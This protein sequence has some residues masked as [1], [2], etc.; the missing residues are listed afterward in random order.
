MQHCFRIQSSPCRNPAYFRKMEKLID[1]KNLDDIIHDMLTVKVSDE[2]YHRA[3]KYR[4]TKI[5]NGLRMSDRKEALS[6]AGQEGT[7][8]CV[9][10][11]GFFPV[12]ADSGR[13]TGIW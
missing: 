13:S 4:S 11:T 10:T 6:P 3:N 12:C 2:L 1:R 8:I 5:S 7:C 9:K